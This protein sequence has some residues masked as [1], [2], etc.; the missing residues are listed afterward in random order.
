[1]AKRATTTIAPIS[2]FFLMLAPLPF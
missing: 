1:M 2:V